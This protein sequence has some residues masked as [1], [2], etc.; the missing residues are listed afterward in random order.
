MYFK[1][2]LFPVLLSGCWFITRRDAC[3]HDQALGIEPTRECRELGFKPSYD[4][5]TDTDTDSDSDS[6]SDTDSDADA[7]SDTDSDSDTDTDTDTDTGPTMTGETG[8]IDPTT[9]DNDSDGYCE[10]S[11]TDGSIAGDC[12]DTQTSIHPGAVE[13]C[14]PLD[15]DED[16]SGAADDADPGVDVLSY[17]TYYK[18]NDLD[19]V[20]IAG[21][22]D[23]DNCEPNNN[24]FVPPVDVDANG[25]SDWDCNDADPSVCPGCPDPAGGAD[26]NCDGTP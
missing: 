5:D 19:G 7:D 6:D 16:C 18:D 12:D 2:V 15:T 23:G 11:C 20:P 26:Q 8:I 3:E 9:T 4:V 14:D 13:V 25:S 1:W 24:T 17:V 21:V 10:A 22:Q